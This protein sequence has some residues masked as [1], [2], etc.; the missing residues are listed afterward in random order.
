MATFFFDNDISY[1]IVEAL[2]E[3]V[4]PDEHEL[5][6]LRQEFPMG[7]KDID[8]IPEIGKLG[9]ILIS[10]DYNQRRRETEHRALRDSNVKALYLR[11]TGGQH[12]IYADAAR[13]IKNWPKI[14]DWGTKAK[15]GT[16][17]RLDTQ[18]RIVVLTK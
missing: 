11:Q 12:E 6:Y 4:P 8:W 7:T 13:I 2:K 9:W 15:P 1:R 10:K 3:L 18:D 16:L 14:R 5:R 17:A